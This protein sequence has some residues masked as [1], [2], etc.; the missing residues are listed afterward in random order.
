MSE[1]ALCPLAPVT[2]LRVAEVSEPYILSSGS[3]TI[4]FSLLK[5]N[6]DRVKL[7]KL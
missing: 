2:P 3:E 1:G 4:G 5:L 6:L 7:L